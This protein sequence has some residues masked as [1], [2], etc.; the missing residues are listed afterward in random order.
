MPRL[1]TLKPRVASAFLGIR[2]G[3]ENRQST[4]ALHTGSK[5]WQIQRQRVLVRDLYACKA[6]GQF[7]NHV[8]HIDGDASRDVP[9]SALQ[10]LCVSCHGS[11]TRK[12]MQG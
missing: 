7:G 11:K 5:A 3:V 4:R 1:A 12:E 2:A 8:D 10:T 9:D 6:C